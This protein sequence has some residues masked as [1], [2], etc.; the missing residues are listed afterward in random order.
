MRWDVSPLAPRVPL[1][2]HLTSHIV[3]LVTTAERI[4]RARLR[5]GL[6]QEQLAQRVGVAHATVSR[7][8]RGVSRPYTS[9]FN[10]ISQ[11]TGVSVVPEASPA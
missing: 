6:T 11:A 4:K 1:T 5:A 3:R 7:W 9:Q 8:E 10:R 2:S